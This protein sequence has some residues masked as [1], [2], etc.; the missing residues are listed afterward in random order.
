[1][2]DLCGK[3]VALE[4]GTTEEE[5]ATKQNSVC[6]HEG[7]KGV[8]VLVF[9]GQNPVNL[10]VASGRAE[11]GM[12]DSPVVD[13]QINQGHGQFKLLCKC[14]GF[15]PYGIA[16]PKHS[17]MTKPILAALKLL[18]ANGTYTR[19]LSKWGIQSGAISEPLINGARG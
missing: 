7:K 9:P 15:A 12:A 13:Y 3:S 11:V 5:E 17:G 16:I 14:Y 1:V 19:I 4:K 6:K 2:G 10:A 18:M 8:N